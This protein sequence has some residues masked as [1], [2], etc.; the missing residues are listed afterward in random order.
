MENTEVI[1]IGAGPAG[2][3]AAHTIGDRLET[4]VLE[5]RSDRVGGRV[6]SSRAWPDETVD[7][8]ASWLTHELINPVTD[9][10]EKYGIETRESELL[11]FALRKGDGC[12]VPEEK[13]KELFLLYAEIY[14]EVKEN[15]RGYE[16]RGEPD[17][18]A[19]AE[20]ERVIASRKLSRDDELA[21]R[22]FLN[23]SIAEPNASDLGKLSLY[24]WD[25][26]LVF[27]QAASA[28]FPN[29]YVEVFEK[30]AKSMEIRFGHVVTEIARD[31]DG[32][33][34]KT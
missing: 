21:I 22:F 20:F 33:T 24:R 2:I 1:V 13:V 8:G 6:Y 26:D 3:A 10:V 11:N 16:E 17:Q 19:A 32:V 9:L 5:A 29:G 4:I 15:A 14:A 18:P 30:L 12:V 34:V 25:D 23:F 31:R 28:V 27:A 7:L